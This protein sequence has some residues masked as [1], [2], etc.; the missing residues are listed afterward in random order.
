MILGIYNCISWV[1]V[2]GK[3]SD[4]VRF[5]HLFV[6]KMSP[7]WQVHHNFKPLWGI[8]QL[9]DGCLLCFPEGLGCF[10]RVLPGEL[11]PLIFAVIWISGKHS[12]HLGRK[13]LTSLFLVEVV[14]TGVCQD[15]EEF[16]LHAAS[17]RV[18]YKTH[19]MA[20]LPCQTQARKHW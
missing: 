3:Q 17:C 6:R 9:W 16:G 4:G 7:L 2:I 19:P 10:L 13:K 12:E 15:S 11:K 5:F 8:Y 14:V 20:S 18:K 1:M